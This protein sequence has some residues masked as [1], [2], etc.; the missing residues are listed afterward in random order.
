MAELKTRPGGRTVQAYLSSI[1]DAPRRADCQQLVEIMRQ[2]TKAGPRMWGSSIVG[3][4]SY[5]YRYASGREGDWFLTGFSSRK[6]RL[7][8]YIMS[9]FD[10]SADLLKRLGRHTTGKAC[11]YVRT[12][13]DLHLPTLKRLIRGSVRHTL[14][15]HA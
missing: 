2:A 15:T 6:H 11:L 4:G 1:K 5:H 12:L 10:G 8:L 9:G 14:K 7:T 3:F 13:D